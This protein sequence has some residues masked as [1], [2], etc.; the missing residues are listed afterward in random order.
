MKI[1]LLF[2]L[3]LLS[4]LL[5]YASC[6]NK[7]GLTPAMGSSACQSVEHDSWFIMPIPLTAANCD[8]PVTGSQCTLIDAQVVPNIYLFAGS[9]C[10]MNYCIAVKSTG[11]TVT[12]KVPSVTTCEDEGDTPGD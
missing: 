3:L 7:G 6:P 1:K 4:A 2:V 5:T 8:Q 10:L 11:Q 9:G 12:Y